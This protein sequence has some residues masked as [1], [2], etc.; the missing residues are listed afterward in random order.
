MRAMLVVILLE[1]DELPLEISC[2]PEQHFRSRQ[3]RRTVPISRSTTGWE[4]G[5]YGTV[6]IS[7]ML[8]IRKFA[9]H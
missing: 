1:L 6:L 5:T 3:S 7:R 9:Y 8:R 2:G 4:R